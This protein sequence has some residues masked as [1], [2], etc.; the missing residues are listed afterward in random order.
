MFR[1]GAGVH[2]SLGYDR[3][4]GVSDAA[5]VD[6]EHKL[7]VLYDVHPEAERQAEDKNRTVSRNRPDE[8]MSAF[9][10]RL[11]RS[12]DKY[13]FRKR[14]FK[15]NGDFRPN[16]EPPSGAKCLFDIINRK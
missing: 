7:R 9:K 15:T 4:T 6:V 14:V 12:R 13:I 11:Q 5:F 16:P 8:V 3:Q 10:G 2:E 1:R